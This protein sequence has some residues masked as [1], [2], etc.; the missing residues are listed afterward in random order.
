MSDKATLRYGAAACQVDFPNPTNRRGIKPHVDRM[1]RM[2]ALSYPLE[3][4]RSD[5]AIVHIR[6]R[7]DMSE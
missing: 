5:P 6:M 2:V 1:L 3:I 7:Q 4:D